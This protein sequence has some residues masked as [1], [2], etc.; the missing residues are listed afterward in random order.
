ML[1]HHLQKQGAREFVAKQ[2][3]PATPTGIITIIDVSTFEC[4]FR[5]KHHSPPAALQSFLME[6]ADESHDYGGKVKLAYYLLFSIGTLFLYTFF[7]VF[8]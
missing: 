3:C 2:T 7:C 6:L 4:W 8:D 1:C 5:R